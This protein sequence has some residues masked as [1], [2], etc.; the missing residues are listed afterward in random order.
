MPAVPITSSEQYEKAI[1]VLTRIGGTWQGVGQQERFLL[2]SEAQYRAL[3]EANV[4]APPR[5]DGK[6]SKRGS[7][8]GKTAGS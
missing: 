7:N 1:E 4:T 2:V 3:V 8:S 5:K 6:G